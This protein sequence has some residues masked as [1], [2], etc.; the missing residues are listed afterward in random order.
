MQQP[1]SEKTVALLEVFRICLIN[2][3]LDK[4]QVI[5]WADTQ[6]EQE[7]EPAYFLIELSLSGGK[8]INDTISLLHNFIGENK[9]QIA[10]RVVLGCLY[11]EYNASR[12]PLEKVATTIYWLGMHC[13]FS[14]DEQRFIQWLDTAYELAVD[15]FYSTIAEVE[16]QINHFLN[17]YKIFSLEN[18]LQ[19]HE[20]DRSITDKFQAFYQQAKT[21]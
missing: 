19:W 9:P 13:Y 14:A 15:G 8:N 3:V 2:T 12:M 20:I 6:I 1:N 16:T 21:W 11:Q 5:A 17:V 4:Q 18:H 7:T 10:G